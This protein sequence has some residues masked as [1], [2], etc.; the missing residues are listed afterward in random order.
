MPIFPRLLS[1]ERREPQLRRQS[2]FERGDV[3]RAERL[4]VERPLLMPERFRDIFCRQRQQLLEI[5]RTD[6]DRRRGPFEMPREHL[7]VPPHRRQLD[8][9]RRRN[10]DRR[11]R[12]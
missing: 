6:L 5:G 1:K 10:D 7:D 11:S 12:L 9:P 4:H 8:Q 3:G 2:V